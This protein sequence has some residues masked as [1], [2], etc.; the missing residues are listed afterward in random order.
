MTTELLT[1]RTQA[2]PLALA[3][4]AVALQIAYPLTGGTVRDRLS[5]LIVVVLAASCFAHAATTRG[6]AA[7]GA[8][9]LAGGVGF[10]AE[11][12]GVQTGVPFGSY[13][14]GDSLGVRAAGVPL[15]VGLAW[16]MLAW[17][18]ML[19]ARRLV[20]SGPAR[21]VLGA[22]A[23]TA[24]DL[25]LD[26][27]QVAA[28]HWRWTTPQPHLPG[29]ADVPL[30]NYAGWFAVSLVI[31]AIL[32]RAVEDDADDRLGLGLY[33]WLFAGWTVALGVFLGHPVAAAWGALGMGTVAVPLARR[34]WR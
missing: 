3:G 28:G 24:C 7:V 22:W 1:R 23:L 20:A 34:L 17:P 27:Q 13:V 9:A 19:A 6:A 29:V 4:A 16:T 30:S 32:R 15:V 10:V 14:Y 11:I 21:V 31:A 26:P 33:L 8:L 18:A 25:F 5:V 2:L 12:A